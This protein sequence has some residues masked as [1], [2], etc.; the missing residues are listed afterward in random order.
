MKSKSSK[1]PRKL[2]KKKDT[3]FI[4]LFLTILFILLLLYFNIGPA[5]F[6]RRLLK[7]VWILLGIGL[8]PLAGTQYFEQHHQFWKKITFNARESRGELLLY[9]PNSKHTNKSQRFLKK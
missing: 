6:C 7:K 9:L 4:L 1:I 5:V 8:T 3:D 2:S